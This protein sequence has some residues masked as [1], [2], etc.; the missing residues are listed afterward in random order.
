MNWMDRF[1]VNRAISYV[2]GKMGKGW[3]GKAGAIG[4]MLGAI[5][6]A[7]ADVNA[8]TMNAE[9]AIGYFTAFS[10]GF[11]AFGIRAALPTSPVT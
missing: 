9:R 6:A 8:G 4:V 10:A 5:A 7:F 3:K 2:E 11:S 1:L